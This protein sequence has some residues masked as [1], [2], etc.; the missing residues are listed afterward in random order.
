MTARS[1]GPLSMDQVISLS[2]AVACVLLLVFVGGVSRVRGRRRGAGGD[3]TAAPT[4]DAAAE[5]APDGT[6]ADWPDPA[7]RPR[8]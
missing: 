8:I 4:P 5:L 1:L 2:I 3:A 7:T 6:R